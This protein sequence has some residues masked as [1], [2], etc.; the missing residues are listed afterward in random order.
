MGT[1]EARLS[2]GGDDVWVV[3]MA[4]GSGKRFWPWSRRSRPKQCLPVVGDASLL[5]QT[6]DRCASIAPAERTIVVTA[7][8][9]AS[10]VQEEL[11]GGE[12]V[13]I[14]PNGRN[15][16]AC[17]AWAARV[18]EDRSGG[19]G[20]MVVAP[21]DH[22]VGDQEAFSGDAAHALDLAADGW[23]VTLGIEPTRP[24]T[25]YGWI[26]TGAPLGDDDGDRRAWEVSEFK[27]KPSAEVASRWLAEGGRVWNSGMFFLRTDRLLGEVARWL[28][29]HADLFCTPGRDVEAGYDGLPPISIDHGVMERADKVAVV[30]ATF[31]WS[32]VGSWASL[33]VADADGSDDGGRSI[34]RGDVLE[35]DGA[36]NVL[37]GEGGLVAVLGVQGLVVAHVGDA[38]LVCPVDRAQEVRRLVDALE[39]AGR[40]DVL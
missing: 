6:L 34:V 3:V 27:E 4:G 20:R 21:A 40:D 39:E 12:V 17:V 2:R 16:A 25:G 32:D 7:Q 31:P 29:V 22:F 37:V 30:A 9:N 8:D 11:R 10:A 5:R 24:E 35:L 23:L 28:P 13:L 38:V 18:V 26:R 1:T 19:V 14:E 33:D 15:T 36:G